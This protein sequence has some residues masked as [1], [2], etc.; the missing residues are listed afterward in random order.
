MCGV[1]SYGATMTTT[2]DRFHGVNGFAAVKVAVKAAT[3]GT[4]TL[5]GEQTIDSV[6]LISGDRVLVKDQA[7]ASENGIYA[8]STSGWDRTVDFNGTR[9]VVPGSLIYVIGGSSSAGTLFA[10]ASSSPITLGT[11]DLA[12]SEV[13]LSG[14]SG[15]SGGATFSIGELP[16]GETRPAGLENDS[17]WL[18]RPAGGI[19]VLVHWSGAVDTSI[20]SLDPAG[21]AAL[22]G[23][24]DAAVQFEASVDG[25]RRMLL[26]PN[27]LDLAVPLTFDGANGFV[28]KGVTV[29][30]LGFSIYNP[31]SGSRLIVADYTGAGGGGGGVNGQGA[32]TTA[33]GQSGG[34][35]GRV[36]KFIY[37]P[38]GPYASFVGA[39]GL[40]GATGDN[41]GTAGEDSTFSGASGVN[42]IGGGGEFGLGGTGASGQT[43]RLPGALGGVATGGDMQRP[44]D[45]SDGTSVLDGRPAILGLP[46]G[47][48]FGGVVLP[49]SNT[50]NGGNAVAKGA[51]GTGAISIN[52]STNFAGGDADDGVG[53]LYEYI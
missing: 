20:V 30:P 24:I 12:F 47:A 5:S 28:F 35:G 32:G 43:A 16:T 2:T 14:G 10:L 48:P 44:G 9:D 46:R 23:N 17:L 39:R 27:A 3:T 15:G 33:L 50:S 18:M 52:N 26:T 38:V 25:T 13:S 41:D 45:Q 22:K 49:A 42:L 29:P 40:G 8:V 53:F 37:D 21:V 51:P 7:D 19:P 4:I 11:T 6:G 36:A 1:F 34:P 31:P